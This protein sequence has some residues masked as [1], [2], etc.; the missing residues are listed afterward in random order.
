MK[1]NLSIHCFAENIQMYLLI[2]SSSSDSL[3]MLLNC[4]SALKNCLN[5]Y[6]LHLNEKENRNKSIWFCLSW[7]PGVI[8]V[9]VI[10][11]KTNF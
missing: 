4:I 9:L 5:I 3:Q 7:P 2:Q 10:L 6:F 1:Y 11:L 8:Y